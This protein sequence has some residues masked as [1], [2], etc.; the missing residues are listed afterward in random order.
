MNNRIMRVKHPKYGRGYV[1]IIADTYF[2]AKFR[3]GKQVDFP[4]T[5]FDNGKLKATKRT[6]ERFKIRQKELLDKQTAE[7]QRNNT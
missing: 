7:R 2:V 5:A 4:L 1:F 6:V 3:D